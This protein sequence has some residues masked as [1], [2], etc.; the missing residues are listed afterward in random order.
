MN[1]HQYIQHLAPNRAHERYTMLEHN[2]L[3]HN[4]S[5]SHATNEAQPN[6]HHV[7][8]TSHCKIN[9]LMLYDAINEIVH[10]HDCL[11]SDGV[12]TCSL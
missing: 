7:I 11:W 4:H 12:Y 5:V 6:Q 2:V 10:V 3:L 9:V 1:N 8:E